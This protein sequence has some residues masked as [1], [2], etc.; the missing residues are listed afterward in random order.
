MEAH[1][2]TLPAP[3]ATLALA[4][5]AGACGGSQGSDAAPPN[6]LLVTL[7]TT[8]ADHLGCYGYEAADTPTL[9]GLAARGTLFEQAYTPAPMT[10]PAHATMFSGLLPPQH[11]ARVNGEHRLA[12][13]VPTLAERLAARG[14]RTGAFVAAF[15]LDGTFGL[16]RGFERYDDDLSGAYVQEVAEHL[17]LYRAGEQVVDAALD[18]LDDEPAT[19]AG[20]RPFFAWV[21]LYDAHYPWH[22][23]D[24]EGQEGTYDG[25]ISYVD[26]QVARLLAFLEA[27]GLA[28][29]TLVVAVADHGEGLGDHGE[30]EHGYLLNEEVLRVPWIMAG[31]GV[32][33]GLRVSALV[34]LEDLMPT[35]LELFG[36]PRPP[37]LPGQSL[38]RAL[39][40]QTIES[41]PSYAETDLPWASYRWAPQRSLT[42]QQFKYVRTPQAELY[43][44]TNDRAELSNLVEVRPK[45]RAELEARLRKM[46]NNLGERASEATSLSQTELDS[47]AALGYVAGDAGPEVP[48]DLEG[49][50]DVKQRR[51]AKVLSERLRR[52]EATDSLE[53][54]ERLEMMRDLVALSPETPS[55]QRQ[56]GQALVE[57]G[58]ED[59]GI[60]KLREAL[61]RD[62]SS[63]DSFY[64]L[65]DVLEQRGRADEARPLFE[66]A[67]KLEP[68]FAA[69]HVGM[70]N[71]L[72]AEGR[73]DLA[74]GQYSEAL[75]LNPR[76]PEAHFN[77]ALTL[78]DRDQPGKA[79]E[80][81]REAVAQR[82]GWGLA[83]AS[84]ARLCANLGRAEEA[85]VAFAAAL[86]VMPRAADL[87]NDCGVTL[88][89]LGRGDEAREHYLEALELRPRFHSAHLNLAHQAT[90]AGRDE[91]ARSHLETALKIVP[92]AAEPTTRL[93]RFLAACPDEGLRDPQRAVALAE[94]AVELTGQKNAQALDTLAIAY[95]ADGRFADAIS[96]AH[97][98]GQRARLDGNESLAEAIEGRLA[99]YALGE[100][101]V[102]TRE[103]DAESAGDG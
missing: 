69:A 99:L 12:E 28:E 30:I 32:G 56:L 46:E 37:G 29:N 103:T 5:L 61:Q 43:D 72:R 15:V 82:P 63:A 44:R 54:E 53:P 94:R 50:A 33:A 65:G 74:A 10:L 11:G 79:L 4:F 92:G 93:A 85:L 48:D 58:H 97:R 14:F 62:D 22:A 102:E 75:R 45:V 9:D 86:E 70:G 47:L 95:A 7:D 2:H 71:V 68:S 41:T 19:G 39:D 59:E 1:P 17:S 16:D 25:E 96:A 35:V 8:R 18:W 98:A 51:G 55:F 31:P 83:H 64:A 21:H 91:E 67:L 101:F 13:D 24:E 73:P 88:D 60:E 81:L 49:L 52:G 66:A 6:L 3:I 40:G 76:Y 89:G 20:A 78:L 42:T 77:L 100:V 80:H 34:S 84:I 87:H 27:G 38:A 26:G 90:A 57:L 23:H 36:L